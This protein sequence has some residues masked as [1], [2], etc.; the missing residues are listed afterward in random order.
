MYFTNFCNAFPVWCR[1]GEHNNHHLVTDLQDQDR[2]K[3]SYVTQL[4][5]S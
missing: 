2:S 1:V 4:P 3:R 5:N